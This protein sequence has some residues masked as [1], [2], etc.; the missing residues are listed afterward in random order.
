MDLLL[1]F[2]HQGNLHTR[3]YDKRDD[4]DFPI[5][6]FPHLCSNIPSSPAYGVYI[7][8]LIRY[9]RAC[10]V[11]DDF[12]ARSRLLTLKLL[13]QNFLLPR[14]K[15]SFKKFYGRHHDLIECYQSSVT[16]MIRD[17]FVT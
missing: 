4:F 17:I 5:V 7:S 13:G 16:A 2:D 3:L 6:N 10:S 11:Y 8:Q 9:S 1:E 12:V 15:S 14:L